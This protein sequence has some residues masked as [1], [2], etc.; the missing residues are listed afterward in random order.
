MTSSLFED[1]YKTMYTYV[2]LVGGNSETRY[3]NSEFGQ[4]KY[5]YNC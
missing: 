5:V 3:E 4:W 2:I 1:S